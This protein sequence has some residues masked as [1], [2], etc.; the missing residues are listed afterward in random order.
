M[1]TVDGNVTVLT[2]Q[3]VKHRSERRMGTSIYLCFHTQIWRMLSVAI[4]LESVLV[5][6]AH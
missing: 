1:A 3:V 4:Q 2:E 5:V 6:A